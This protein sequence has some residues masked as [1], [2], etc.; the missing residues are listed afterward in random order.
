VTR[1]ELE[2]PRRHRLAVRQDEVHPAEG[3]VALERA[4]GRLLLVH[5][6]PARAHAVLEAELERSIGAEAEVLD[7]HRWALLEQE[8]ALHHPV[9]D[10]ETHGQARAPRALHP[11]RALPRAEMVF[12]LGRRRAGEREQASDGLR[13]LARAR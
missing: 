8:L 11:G 3:D 10:P 1:V 6:Q 7:A 12:H 13:R 4:A 5:D 9:L 2:V